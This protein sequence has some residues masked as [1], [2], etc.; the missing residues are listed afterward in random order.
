MDPVTQQVI[1]PPPVPHPATFALAKQTPKRLKGDDD[2]ESD[3]EDEIDADYFDPNNEKNQ[4]KSRI[5][6]GC[7]LL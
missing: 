7:N 2:T 1:N 6:Q 5:C 3:D 4:S